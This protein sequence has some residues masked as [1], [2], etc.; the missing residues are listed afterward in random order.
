MFSN[1]KL[2]IEIVLILIISFFYYRI[3]SR[4][5]N[6][7]SELEKEIHQLKSMRQPIQPQSKSQPQSQPQFQHQP[8]SANNSL[9]DELTN[10]L[11]E[12][13]KEQTKK[14]VHFDL[15]EPDS[16]D[17]SNIQTSETNPPVIKQTIPETEPP[18]IEQTRPPS[19]QTQSL[20]IQLDSKL[21]VKPT[22]NKEPLNKSTVTVPKLN[23]EIKLN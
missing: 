4:Y 18:V 19:V 23:R 9:D 21:N 17:L 2:L 1:R 7:I 15:E 20:N 12:L 3:L 6:Q 10:E 22:P 13:M 5:K 8:S 16:P 11:Q 14:K